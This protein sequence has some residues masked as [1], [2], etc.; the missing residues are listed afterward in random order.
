MG[1]QADVLDITPTLEGFRTY[2]KRYEVIKRLIPD[3][4]RD[5]RL[6]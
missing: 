4:I 1:V 5:K 3:M 2:A 6:K